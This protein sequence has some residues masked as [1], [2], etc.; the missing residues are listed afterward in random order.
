MAISF[1]LKR[2]FSSQIHLPIINVNFCRNLHLVEGVHNFPTKKKFFFEKKI[3]KKNFF[4]KNFK[5]IFVPKCRKKGFQMIFEH[6]RDDI[7]FFFLLVFF[8]IFDILFFFFVFFFVFFL[9][10]IF[11]IGNNCQNMLSEKSVKT[12]LN[13]RLD[14]FLH[15]YEGFMQKECPPKKLHRYF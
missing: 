13:S 9:N 5:K 11:R 7:F 2:L 8:L 10:F 15:F 6:F 1:L 12:V 3:T 14:V 4:A